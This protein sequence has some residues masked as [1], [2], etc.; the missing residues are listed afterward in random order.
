MRRRDLS[1]ALLASAVGAAVSCERAAAQAGT[2]PCCTQTAAE[3]AASV[4]PVNTSVLPGQPDRYAANTMPGTTDMSAGFASAYKQAQQLGGAPVLIASPLAITKSVKLPVGVP[5]IFTGTGSINI[6]GS[7]ITLT[8]QG[9]V[10]GPRNTVFLG[11]GAV[12][13]TQSAQPEVYPEWWGCRG[14]SLPNR[15][16]GFTT[17]G[18]DCTSALAACILAAAGGS[19]LNVGVIPIRIGNGY[20]MTGNQTLPPATV[21]RGLGRETCGFIAKSGTAGATVGPSTGAWFTDGGSASKII[22]ED[23]AMY[24][25]YA[26]C[27]AMVYALRLGYNGTPHGTEGYLRGLWVRDCA[28]FANGCVNGFQCDILG[29]VGFYD[30]LSIYCNNMT[31]Q[32][33]LRIL[34]TCNMCSRLV[35][36]AAGGPAPVPSAWSSST[37]YSVNAV[38]SRG[39]S[40]YVCIVANSGEMPANTAY[41]L[42][43]SIA[44]YGIYLNGQGIQVQGMEIEAVSSGAIPLSL[45]NN[46][47]INGVVFSLADGQTLDH[48]WELGANASTWKLTG[49]NYVF[50]NA[51]TARVTS[52]N[53]LRADG[54]YFAGNATGIGNVVPWSSSTAY[55]A[56]SIVSEAG[57]D[58]ISVL[59][60]TNRIPPN[61]AYWNIYNLA[62][63]S[64]EGNW[65]SDTNAQ[66]LQSFTLRITNT[67]TA[68]YHYIAE[69]GG[70]TT[71]FASTIFG[72]TAIP[73]MTPTGMDSTT[74]FAG[75]GTI[76]YTTPSIFWLNT[77]NQRIAD[78]IGLAFVSFNTTGTA[79]NVI[80]SIR[81]ANIAGVTMN[82]LCFQLTNAANGDYFPLN[83][84]NIAAGKFVQISWL[85]T[86]A[87]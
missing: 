54:S 49:V 69:P 29:N 65:F 61:P 21:I 8:I 33:G 22:L 71:N 85:G 66:R 32:S 68:L 12:V 75:G 41:W 18:T 6:I 67:G 37:R 84:T 28:C 74:A 53:G 46:T 81:S 50:G 16:G 83:T 70:T 4:T 80:A 25:S 20:Y 45:Q 34:G 64:G 63:H 58:Y 27:P 1:N 42:P 48:V 23:F 40:N 79:L 87:N 14:D 62:P 76:V 56:G 11:T 30:L 86:L 13:F 17:V 9:Y 72:A 60:N 19:G 43:Y 5:I 73:T 82:R 52:G 77:P 57:S 10:G 59:A 38:V 39:G 78:T 7:A 3:R 15:S 2:A 24:A 36:V 55:V 44:T 35:S 31:G 47:D 26:V 51:K